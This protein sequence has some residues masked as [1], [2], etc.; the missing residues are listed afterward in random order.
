MKNFNSNKPTITTTEYRPGD[1]VTI[2]RII[3]RKRFWIFGPQVE[4]RRVK[5]IH[6]IKAINQKALARA[7]GAPANEA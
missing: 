3:T 6:E 7:Q 1:L 5:E 4:V 2:E